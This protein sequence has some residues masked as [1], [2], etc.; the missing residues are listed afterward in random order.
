MI[1]LIP[2]C[3]SHIYGQD[4]TRQIISY[5]LK[6]GIFDTLAP[7]EMDF[8]ASEDFTASMRGLDFKEEELLPVSVNYSA[9][10]LVPSTQFSN[11]IVASSF[12][13]LVKYPISTA[14]KLFDSSGDG[15]RDLCSG[16]M[17]SDRHVLSSGHCI[18]AAYTSNANTNSVE[19]QIFYDA[20]LN[21]VRS[22]SSK[23]RKIYFMEGWNI[24][25]GDDIAILELEEN[26]GMMSGWMSIGYNDDDAYFE[27]KH[28]HKL[29]YPAY[30]TPFND[31]PYNGDTLYY[32]HGNVDF[33][34]RDFL[35]VLRHLNGVG[36]ESGSPIFEHI[37]GDRCVAYG[38]L[39][40]LGNYSHSRFDKERFYAFSSILTESDFSTSTD[41]SLDPID[42]NLFPNPAVHNIK[43]SFPP[44]T[45]MDGMNVKI[46]DVNGNMLHA[47]D[48]LSRETS[49]FIDHLPAGTLFLHISQH[50][51][52]V[53]TRPFIKY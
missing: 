37:E 34:N 52:I 29:S 35:G 20:S 39:T 31:F 46:F 2:L 1:F 40:W 26:I 50:N 30:N 24:S 14:V 49:L 38:V 36:G 45:N 23:V 53:A 21:V 27:N 6:T 13:D 10:D 28:M 51:Q 44:Q 15:R 3:G 33:I 17:I 48:L 16:V 11:P 42:F 12:F 18:F 7:V 22:Y 47:T 5:D 41:E 25:F 4:F 32:S 19:A 9:D 43:V 8:S